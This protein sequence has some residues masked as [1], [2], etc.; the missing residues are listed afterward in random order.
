[1]VASEE[2][3][4]GLNLSNDFVSIDRISG[5][6]PGTDYRTASDLSKSFRIIRVHN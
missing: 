4:V 6:C 2:Y 1:M 3:L 5:L